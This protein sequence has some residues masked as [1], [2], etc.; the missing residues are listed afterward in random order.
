MEDVVIETKK[1]GKENPVIVVIKGYLDSA[2]SYKLVEVVDGLLNEGFVKII[3]NMGEL[4]YLS[5]AGISVVSESFERLKEK[6]GALKLTNVSQRVLKVLDLCGVA[7]LLDIHAEVDT[8]YKSFENIVKKQESFPAEIKCPACEFKAVIESQDIYKCPKCGIIFY[9]DEKLKIELLEKEKTGGAVSKMD[10]WIKADISYIT[11]IRRM[12][13][14]IALREGFFEDSVH[15]IEL[16]LDESITNIIEH[17]YNF[18][19]TKS[20]GI[21]IATESDKL[22]ISITDKGKSFDMQKLPENSFF[23]S[24]GPYRGRGQHIIKNTMDAVSYAP[25]SGVENKLILTK[26]KKDSDKKGEAYIKVV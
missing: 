14:A 25:I 16:A 9:I 2:T 22:I 19:A 24:K 3:F 15:E 23:S 12:V 13:G 8:A 7:K 26:I 11:P 10:M 21:N 17:G 5:S 18:D 6:Q 4:E 1:E 20:I